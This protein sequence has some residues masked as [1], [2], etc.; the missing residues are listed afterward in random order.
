MR[1]TVT[2]ALA[3]VGLLAFPILA[4]AQETVVA[5]KPEVVATAVAEKWLALVD[6]EKYAESWQTAA[7]ALKGVVSQKKWKATLP[8]LRKP[9]GKLVARQFKSAAW[10]TELAGAP[11]GEYVVVQFATQF[12]DGKQAVET[13]TPMKDK[14]GQWRVSGYL[15]K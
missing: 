15:I 3:L 12:A 13:V 1:S 14:D 5:P 2:C 10:T 9:L 6:A 11:E 7:A 8:T 4:R